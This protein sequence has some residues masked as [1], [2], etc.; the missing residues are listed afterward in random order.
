MDM[1][2]NGKKVEFDSV[3]YLTDLVNKLT[4]EDV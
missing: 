4:G 3:G 2:I 1:Y